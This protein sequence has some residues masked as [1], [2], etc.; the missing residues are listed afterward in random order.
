MNVAEEADA[1]RKYT[2]LLHRPLLSCSVGSDRASYVICCGGKK[3]M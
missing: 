1:C 3:M 2:N